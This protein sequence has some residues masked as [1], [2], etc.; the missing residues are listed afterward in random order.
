MSLTCTMNKNLLCVD[1]KL[2]LRSIEELQE[3]AESLAVGIAKDKEKKH[4]LSISIQRNE[5]LREVALKTIIAKHTGG[6]IY[7][8]TPIIDDRRGKE[9]L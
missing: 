5:D 2:H 9:E 8:S 7:G 3:L 6:D 1:H 4:S